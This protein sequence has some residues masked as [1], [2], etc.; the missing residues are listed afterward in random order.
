M[1]K[2]TLALLL[3]LFSN[4]Y[5]VYGQSIV[6]NTIPASCASCCD[7][8]FTMTVVYTTSF[9][10]LSTPTLGVTS[11]NANVLVF[12]NVCA[13]A[14]TI[15]IIG[16]EMSGNVTDNFTMPFSTGLFSALESDRSITFYPNPA[17]KNIFTNYLP[18]KRFHISDETGRI[19]L[20]QT[21]DA[22]EISI[23]L[24]E[25]GFYWVTMFTEDNQLIGRTK[26]IKE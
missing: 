10:F 25:S 8:A 23:E 3:L 14:Y 11:W 12:N 1:R 6:Y 15:N 13:G 2:L 7:G 19:V 17:S 20:E 4:F 26:M 9:A 18:K 24:L 22:N 5:S 21:T 16:S